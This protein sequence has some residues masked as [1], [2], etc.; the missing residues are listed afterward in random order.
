MKLPEYF[1]QDF[2]DERAF[3][4]SSF[5]MYSKKIM[6]KHY[7]DGCI[8]IDFQSMLEQYALFYP[9]IKNLEYFIDISINQ[10]FNDTNLYYINLSSSSKILKDLDG[11]SQAFHNLLD[12]LRD[13]LLIDDSLCII[14]LMNFYKTSFDA[15][16]KVEEYNKNLKTIFINLGSYKNDTQTTITLIDEYFNKVNCDDSIKENFEF[17]ICNNESDGVD[18]YIKRYH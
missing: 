9:K 6:P 7:E 1:G 4:Y 17:I 8:V 16:N 11:G 13:T 2:A 10:R 14:P 18:E 5:I 3:I 15:M 12:Y